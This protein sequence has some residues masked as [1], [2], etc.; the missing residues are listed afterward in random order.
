LAATPTAVK[1]AY[2]LA[3]G[4][5]P[6]SLIDAAG[7]LIVGT[8]ADTA[9]RLGIGTAG[10]VLKVNSGATAL[11]W[12]TA[13]GGGK[14][15]Q[16]VSATTTTTTTITST[17]LTDS[18]ITATITPTSATSQILVIISAATSVSK[19]AVEGYGGAK[20]LRGGTT[21]SDFGTGDFQ[22]VTAD[23]PTIAFTRVK[24]SPAI[25][26]YDSPATTSATTYKV[27]GRGLN[28]ST[29]IEFQSGNAPSTI[30]L[31]EIGA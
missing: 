26:Y 1:S 28:A 11:E 14:V 19:A 21:I 2:D 8:A 18:G 20:L 25:T 9:G 12:G 30:T 17:T 4:A 13:G 29:T 27:Q 23:A 10:Q 3:D 22:G 24:T 31:L 5:I 16:V 7:D 6:E 15:L